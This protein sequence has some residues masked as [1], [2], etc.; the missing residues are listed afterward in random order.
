[1]NRRET[2]LQ[3]GLFVNARDPRFPVASSLHDARS[4]HAKRPPGFQV[5]KDSPGGHT[6]AENVASRLFISAVASTSWM[7]ASDEFRMTRMLLFWESSSGAE[8][9]QVVVRSRR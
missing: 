7:T 9:D 6:A 3:F 1:M 8:T 2:S 5:A 4:S